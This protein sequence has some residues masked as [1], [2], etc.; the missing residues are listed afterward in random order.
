M[1]AGAAGAAGRV[2][3]R[4]DPRLRRTASPQ[5]VPPGQ[6][7]PGIARLSEIVLA[8]NCAV[9]RRLSNTPAPLFSLITASRMEIA[10]PRKA[11]M[12]PGALA[13]PFPL[14]VL[15]VVGKPGSGLPI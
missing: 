12:P 5:V 7:A 1:T 15:M 4:P 9:E 10:A 2:L 8:V 3:N 14:T 11:E 13:L 6:N